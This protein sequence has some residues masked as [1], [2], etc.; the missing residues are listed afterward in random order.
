MI[1]DYKEPP[2][3]ARIIAPWR[4]VLPGALLLGALWG[5][6]TAGGYPNLAA[7]FHFIMVFKLGCAGFV[8]VQE[9]WRG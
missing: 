2:L 3:L 7:V 4:E 9:I 8:T 1:E 6:Y 5:I